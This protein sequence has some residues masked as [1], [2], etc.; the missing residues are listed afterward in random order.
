[1][2][3]EDVQRD[4]EGQY[5][6]H[7]DDYEEVVLPKSKNTSLEREIIENEPQLIQ[8]KNSTAPAKIIQTKLAQ[9]KK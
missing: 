6:D 3:D 2:D 4:D 7:F 8:L 1:M 9:A 5:S